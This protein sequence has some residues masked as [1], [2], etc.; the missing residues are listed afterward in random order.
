MEDVSFRKRQLEESL[1]SSE[2]KLENLRD[3][4]EKSDQLTTNMMA[5]LDSFTVRLKKLDDTIVPVYKQTK[6]LTQ[7]QESILHSV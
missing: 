6:E 4:L 7:L 2:R 5:I 3:S 1:K